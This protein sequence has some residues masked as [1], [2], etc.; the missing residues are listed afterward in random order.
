M[1]TSQTKQRGRTHMRIH[2]VAPVIAA[3]LEGASDLQSVVR[4]DVE[5]SRGFLDAGPASIESHFDEALALPDTLAKVLEAERAGADAIVIDCM[6]DPALEAAREATST[7]VLGPGAASMHLAALLGHTFSILAVLDAVVPM[8]HDI[9]RRA[10]LAEKLCSIRT[11]DIPVLELERERER[12]DAALLSASI[13]AIEEDGAHVIVF[14]CT[15]MV[16]CADRLRQGLAE[17]G[18]DGIPVIDPVVATV[19]LA[20]ALVDLGLTPSTRTYPAPR[21]KEIAGYPAV[22]GDVPA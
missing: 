10:G 21:D 17:R 7:L 2:V 15:G 1:T 11:V 19:K 6:G 16:G 5:I 18:H 3:E 8:L 22:T 13:A 12:L 20:E 9:A 4:P 14:G